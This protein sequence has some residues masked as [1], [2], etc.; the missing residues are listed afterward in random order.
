MLFSIGE[1]SIN[2]N[3]VS[4]LPENNVSRTLE[5]KSILLRLSH[6]CLYSLFCLLIQLTENKQNNETAIIVIF[7]VNLVYF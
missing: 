6:I 2:L 3:S 4:I 7:T 1:C 5:G